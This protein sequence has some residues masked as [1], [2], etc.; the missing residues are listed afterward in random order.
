M[1][2]T[3]YSFEARKVRLTSELIHVVSSRPIVFM[4]YSFRVI[5]CLP[6]VLF[7]TS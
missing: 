6:A 5:V 2:S 7:V 3:S 4:G 1:K